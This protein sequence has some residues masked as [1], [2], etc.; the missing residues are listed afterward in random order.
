MQ[1]SSPR[2][3]A[4]AV[5][6]GLSFWFFIISSTLNLFSIEAFLVFVVTVFSLMQFL[7]VKVSNA[8][9][10]FAIYNTKVFLGIL[11]VFVVSIYGVLFR[12]LKIDLL[13]LKKQE[14]SYWLEFERLNRNHIFK[15]Y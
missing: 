13:R 4:I 10:I 11:F 6:I 7:A 12:F 15:Q 9:E 1:F 5:S 14:N 2:F 8:L 3:K